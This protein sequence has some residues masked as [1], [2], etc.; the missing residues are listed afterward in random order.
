MSPNCK[1]F[2]NILLIGIIALFLIGGGGYYFVSKDKKVSVLNQQNNQG[3]NTIIE[4]ISSVNGLKAE[5]RIEGYQYS[6]VLI[7]GGI[8]KNI[9]YCFENPASSIRERNSEMGL[10]CSSFAKPEF[11]PKGNYLMYFL[12]NSTAPAQKF[13]YNIKTGKKES[14]E[15]VIFSNDEKYFSSCVTNDAGSIYSGVIYNGESLEEIYSVS[16]NDAEY[17]DCRKTT[18]NKENNT[19]T[20]VFNGSTNRGVEYNLDTGMSYELE[21]IGP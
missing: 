21:Q 5:V 2:A 8:E 13:L 20:F 1:G 19:F 16:P 14:V 4:E 9:D 11:S 12:T 6:I 3:K 10:D 18:Y 17:L 7:E 15:D